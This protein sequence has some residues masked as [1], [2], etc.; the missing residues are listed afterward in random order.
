MKQFI[1]NACLNL[2]GL[3]KSTFLAMLPEN[4]KTLQFFQSIDNEDWSV[5]SFNT[6]NREVCLQITSVGQT[7]T[8]SV[9]LDYLNPK[10]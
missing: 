2:A 3:S 8:I 5:L 1:K 4:S 9:T 6:S 7:K 10:F